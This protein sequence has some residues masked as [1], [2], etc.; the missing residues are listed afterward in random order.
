VIGVSDNYETSENKEAMEYLILLRLIHIVC[1]VIWTGGMI[2]LAFFVIPAAK[3]IGPDGTKFIQ[4]LYSTN[5]LPIIMNVAAI[6]SIA[7]GIIL[8]QKLL[9]GLQPALSSTHGIIIVTGALLALIGFI[10]GLSVNLP[11]ARRMNILGKM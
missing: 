8:M 7:T 9:G 2:Y 1:T 10:I 4:Q 6:L 11:I 3:S 5:K